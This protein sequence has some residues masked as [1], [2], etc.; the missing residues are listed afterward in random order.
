ML[1]LSVQ[2]VG[3]RDLEEAELT[4]EVKRELEKGK[5]IEGRRVD[6]L[7]PVYLWGC[8]ELGHGILCCLFEH[9][10]CKTC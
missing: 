6:F 8:I 1:N 4:R 10:P 2:L 9:S 7:F 5:V 3:K